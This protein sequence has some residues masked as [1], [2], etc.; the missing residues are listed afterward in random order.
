MCIKFP[1]RPTARPA[2]SRHFHKLIQKSANRAPLKIK[3][4]SLP[5]LSSTLKA[6]TSKHCSYFSLPAFRLRSVPRPTEIQTKIFSPT[7]IS[8]GRDTDQN[9]RLSQYAPK[10]VLRSWGKS[11]VIY[12]IFVHLLRENRNSIAN[13][14]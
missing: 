12:E 11:L 10:N 6:P 1:K 7:R 5:A 13:P 9:F 2:V 3:G 8:V 14:L 4:T